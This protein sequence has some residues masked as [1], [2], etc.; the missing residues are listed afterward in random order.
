[1]EPN[2]PNESEAERRSRAKRQRDSRRST[3][4]VTREQLRVATTLTVRRDDREK[5]RENEIQRNG[6]SS[7][8]SL[9]STSLHE[10]EKKVGEERKDL[11]TKTYSPSQSL[12][13]VR[14]RSQAPRTTRRVTGPVRIDDLQSEETSDD[15]LQKSGGDLSSIGTI[16]RSS[17]N[18][19]SNPVTATTSY[20]FRDNAL[21]TVAYNQAALT[22]KI[23][24]AQ[25]NSIHI[26]G[27][28]ASFQMLNSRANCQESAVDY[29]TLYEKE[30]Q[31]T[32]RLRRRI[33]ELSLE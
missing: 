30:K 17:P 20:N 27:S 7:S 4:G 6:K 29:K 23:R 32:E 25:T 21:T 16:I 22:N 10:I 15:S 3:Q 18:D 28:T 14:R 2:M 19:L 9:E 1:M 33:E 26:G 8:S 12:S 13:A 24:T 11:D 5:E 31:E